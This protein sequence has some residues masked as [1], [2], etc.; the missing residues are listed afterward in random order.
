MKKIKAKTKKRII[1][2]V[3]TT[4]IFAIGVFFDVFSIASKGLDAYK[5]YQVTTSMNKIE[6]FQQ[7][8]DLSKQIAKLSTQKQK[9]ETKQAQ[10]ASAINI[11]EGKLQ[12]L[13]A[14]NDTFKLGTTEVNKESAQK[15]HKQ[16]TDRH[17]SLT[18]KIEY[19]NTILLT[20]QE[21]F[22]KANAIRD[23]LEEDGLEIQMQKLEI[24]K[25]QKEI[26][27]LQ[28]QVQEKQDYINQ[29]AQDIKDE[30]SA[31]QEADIDNVIFNI[32][33]K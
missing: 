29:K 15:L 32:N 28:Q 2:T 5:D 21:Q 20:K 19:V 8:E 16:L 9:L 22:R 11:L 12:E 1:Y 6:N 18:K 13:T 10:C 30:D 23:Q 26:N 31:Q 4:F 14:D 25:L 3:L 27:A 24:E 33:E 17:E 7:D